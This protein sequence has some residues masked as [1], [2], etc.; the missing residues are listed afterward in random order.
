MGLRVNLSEVAERLLAFADAVTAADYSSHWPGALYTEAWPGVRDGWLELR[1]LQDGRPSP[2]INYAT[3]R[4]TPSDQGV[5]SGDA[6]G[7]EYVDWQL[8]AVSMAIV[9]VAT[10]VNN[11]PDVVRDAVAELRVHASII[12][13]LVDRERSRRV[14][15]RADFAVHGPAVGDPDGPVTA[16]L[17]LDR[18]GLNLPRVHEQRA[19]VDVAEQLV[20]A[21]GRWADFKSLLEL[22]KRCPTLSWGLF[23]WLAHMQGDRQA[24]GFLFNWRLGAQAEILRQARLAF[25]TTPT[26]L[27]RFREKVIIPLIDEV[28]WTTTPDAAVL[29]SVQRVF[30]VAAGLLPGRSPPPPV[31]SQPV[32]LANAL[33][34]LATWTTQQADELRRQQSPPPEP[35]TP[36][37]PLSVKVVSVDPSV[38]VDVQNWPPPPP[39]ATDSASDHRTATNSHDE[40]PLFG[41]H[42]II[43]Q[44]LLEA[45]AT[46]VNARLTAQ[47]IVNKGDRNGDVNTYKRPLSKLL[48]EE[49]LQVQLNRG[50][51]YWLTPKGKSLAE[52]I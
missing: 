37:D 2:T 29:A 45:G 9:A 14:E 34:T 33:H 32:E 23:D 44:V 51:G 1:L 19:A 39:R 28:T 38:R 15:A 31:A 35:L 7:Y 25:P 24:F 26:T 46:H 4:P 30:G 17:H 5:L 52:R 20:I 8:Y 48:R 22:G 41:P 47:D 21:D 10:M 12:G 50:G 18:R 42:R 6:P 27:E 16:S 11:D 13:T 3:G 40:T 43:L 49:I 36:A